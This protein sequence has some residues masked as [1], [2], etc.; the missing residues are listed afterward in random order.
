MRSLFTILR[1]VRLYVKNVQS[2]ADLV[3]GGSVWD[4]TPLRPQIPEK[5]TIIQRGLFPLS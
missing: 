3:K 5:N 1:I 4:I 2:K